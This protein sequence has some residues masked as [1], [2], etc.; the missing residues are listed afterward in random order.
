MKAG[1]EYRDLKDSSYHS[2]DRFDRFE[3][4]M[5]VR[6]RNL[7]L[8]LDGSAN[9]GSERRALTILRSAVYDAMADR[10]DD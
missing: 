6:R 1:V 7:Y 8:A 3:L 9:L 5:V 4:E 2:I 10:I